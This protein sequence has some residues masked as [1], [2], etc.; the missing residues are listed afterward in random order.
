MKFVL[1]ESLRVLDLSNSKLSVMNVEDSNTAS[2]GICVE[3]LFGMIT[4]LKRLACLNLSGVQE[5]LEVPSSIKKL[6]NLQVLVLNGCTKL[7]K[8][9]AK[10]TYL[11]R[12]VVLDIGSCP[13][14]HLPWNLGSLS[15]LEELSGFRVVSRAKTQ[16]ATLLEL[17]KLAQLRVLRIAICDDDISKEEKKSLSSLK[18]LKVLA[19]D[20]AEARS[21]ERLD[22]IDEL[23]LP[24]AIEELYL[25]NYHARKMPKWFSHSRLPKLHYL[26]IEDC[27][28]ESLTDNHNR[29]WK[30]EGLYLKLLHMLDVDWDDLHN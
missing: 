6:L 25:R 26:S 30:I 21:Q 14:K 24:P 1:L 22:M 3:E 12:L 15:C 27:E 10:I 11:K 16:G 23:D 13:I 28:V 20:A 19:I 2:S 29:S 8:I 18:N 7:G 17:G 9:P 4:S 5:L